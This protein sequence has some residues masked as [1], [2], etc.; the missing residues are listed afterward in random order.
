M[1][2]FDDIFAFSSKA[3]GNGTEDHLLCTATEDELKSFIPHVMSLPYGSR[4]VEIGTYSGRSTSVYFQLQKELNLDIHLV[5]CWNWNAKYAAQIFTGMVIDFFNE[6]PFTFHKMISEQVIPTWNLP[7]D[8]LY[9]DGAHEHPEVDYD[10]E[11]WPKFVKSGGILAAHDST[12]PSVLHCL[13]KYIRGQGWEL[14][15]MAGPHEQWKDRLTIW[16]KP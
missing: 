9:L 5:D 2:S 11:N 15:D 6:V 1:R 16:K 10:F 14:I 8:F 3:D 7:I 13:D 4:V 12:W